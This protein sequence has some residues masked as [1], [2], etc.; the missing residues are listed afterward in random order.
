VFQPF[1]KQKA[2]EIVMWTHTRSQKYENN[3]NFTDYIELLILNMSRTERMMF[4]CHQQQ[5]E[6]C[7]SPIRAYLVFQT[8]AVE[9]Q[10]I[11]AGLAS[12]YQYLLWLPPIY[13]D[14][15]Q[16]KMQ[17][18]NGDYVRARL[19]EIFAKINGRTISE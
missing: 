17:T 9:D 16:I 12:H 1:L 15:C 19:G 13:R 4:L 5:Q 18:E 11:V 6:I 7:T 14:D 10:V 8:L 2:Y 3:R